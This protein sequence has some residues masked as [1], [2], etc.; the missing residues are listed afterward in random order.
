MIDHRDDILRRAAVPIELARIAVRDTTKART[1]ELPSERW[2]SDASSIVNDPDIDVV[3]EAIGGVDAARELIVERGPY[4]VE[5][6][7][8]RLPKLT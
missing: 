1:V 4:D 5:S 8:R 7:R 2:T 6:V 3:V